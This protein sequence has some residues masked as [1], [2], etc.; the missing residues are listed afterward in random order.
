MAEDTGASTLGS[1]KRRCDQD[2]TSQSNPKRVKVDIQPTTGA[3]APNLSPDT[4]I[5]S[6]SPKSDATPPDTRSRA[7][8]RRRTA[9]TSGGG[10]ATVPRRVKR[11]L[12]HRPR[13]ILKMRQK[14]LPV[15]RNVSLR[16]Y[17]A[18]VGRAARACR[19]QCVAIV[20]ERNRRSTI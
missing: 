7:R 2:T 4:P 16:S 10:V 18:F 19:C 5:A 1:T 14:R 13:L 3:S 11:A 20:S 6:R 8:E 9:R 15:Y 12:W 17:S